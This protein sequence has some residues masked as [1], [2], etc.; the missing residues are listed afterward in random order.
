MVNYYFFLFYLIA[1]DI[2]IIIYCFLL[3]KNGGSPKKQ[4]PDKLIDIKEVVA[5]LNSVYG[6]MQT[7]EK[8]ED[9]FP[10]QQKLLLCSLMLI[11]NKGR[12]KDVTVDKV[13]I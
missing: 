5:I 2:K 6:G 3:A 1:D 9:I 10:L 11:R 4:Q 7:I 12:N 8:D 13:N